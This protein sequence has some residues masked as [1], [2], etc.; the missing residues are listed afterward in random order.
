MFIGFLIGVSIFTV[1]AQTLNE[2]TKPKDIPSAIIY[3]AVKYNVSVAT[4]TRI[5][6]CE[7]GMK[8]TYEDG[9]P[10]LG[11]Q[12]EIGVFQFMPRTFYGWARQMGLKNPNILDW[13]D[14]ANVAAWG[15]SQ[16][17]KDA[18]VCK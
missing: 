12:Q 14:Q 2:G 5:A 15:I 16:G 18:W 10:V 9:Y 8:Q 6:M 13:E 7:S 17:K 11:Q 1:K 3:Y 4:L